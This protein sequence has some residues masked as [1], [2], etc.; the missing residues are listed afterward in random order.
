MWW[1]KLNRQRRHIPFRRI[2]QII[3]WFETESHFKMISFIQAEIVNN[4]L[5]RN[6]C[7]SQTHPLKQIAMY[8]RDLDNIFQ[9]SSFIH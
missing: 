6:Y 7:F 8:Y 5:I 2:I 1:Y 9:I 4:H 3:E